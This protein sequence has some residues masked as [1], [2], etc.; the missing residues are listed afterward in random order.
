MSTLT[1]LGLPLCLVL[2]ATCAEPAENPQ[3][4]SNTASAVSATTQADKSQT[5]RKQQKMAMANLGLNHPWAVAFLPDGQFLVS[6]RS[7]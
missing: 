7:D 4:A 6:E 5:A 2:S 3:N 1:R